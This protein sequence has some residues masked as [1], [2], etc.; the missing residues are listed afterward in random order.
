[1]ILQGRIPGRPGAW[2]MSYV[3]GRVDGLFCTDPTFM[4]DRCRWI[5]PGL[6][7][8]QINGIS[9]INFTDASL[10]LG[11]IE[12]ADALVRAAGVSRYC[13]TVISSSLD[14]AR[15]V[16]STFRRA[17]DQG[18]LPG[19][20]AIHLEGPWISGLEGPRGVHRKE[21]VRAVSLSEWD[22]LR[23]AAAGRIRLLTL[24]PELSGA[25]DLARKA[26]RSGTVVSIGHTAA[27][28]D[29]IAGA[30]R[31]GARMSTHLF[32][33]CARLLDRHSN[34]VYS[35]LAED[36]LRACFIADGHHV[37][38]ATLRIGI[39]TKGVGKSILVSDLAH[40]SG[41]PEGDY[42][43]EGNVV[44]LRDG[45]LRVKGT[46]LL[47]GA[48]RSLREDVELLGRQTE[49]GIEAALLMA[50]RSPAD[51]VGDLPWADLRPGRRGPGRRV[52]VGR[53][54]APS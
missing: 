12:R 7:D 20:W 9:G 27:S 6:F 11:Q 43:M 29:Q 50:T 13:P 54:A 18:R 21:H 15:A 46:G 35:Q 23:Q 37:P 28:A 8:L 19:A 14:T 31:A 47:S 42:E 25:L 5:T 32:N 4:D 2:E 22:A 52:F 33:G 44:E 38:F 53:R 39:R 1:M 16:L 3:D 49:P 41:L 26:A 45:G 48:A 10:S 24:A 40:L 17:W 51:A 36:R 30:V 34:V